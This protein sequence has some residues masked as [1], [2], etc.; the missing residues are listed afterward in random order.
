[1]SHFDLPLSNKLRMNEGSA[2][3]LQQPTQILPKQTNIRRSVAT[4]L[5]SVRN[6]DNNSTVSNSSS[7]S[8]TDCCVR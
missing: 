4:T 7:S 2:A 5:T 8:R 3:Q 6:Y 1:M